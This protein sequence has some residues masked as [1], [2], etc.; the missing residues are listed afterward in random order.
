MVPAPL[1]EPPYTGHTFVWLCEPCA[2]NHGPSREP[3][4]TGSPFFQYS[5]GGLCFMCGRYPRH[6][7]HR[8][9]SKAALRSL[10]EDMLS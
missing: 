6:V 1:T 4:G 8:P 10:A 9:L 7:E 3:Y 5:A 2:T